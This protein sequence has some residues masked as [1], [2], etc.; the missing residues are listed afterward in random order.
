MSTISATTPAAAALSATALAALKGRI[1]GAMPIG[2]QGGTVEGLVQ[3][4]LRPMLK[5]WLDVHLPSMV[6]TLVR[7]E[8]QRIERQADQNR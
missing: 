5:Q 6:E 4:L 8:I 2:A 7:E 1:S 3:E